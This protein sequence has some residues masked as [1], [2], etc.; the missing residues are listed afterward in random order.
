ME[1]KVIY[2]LKYLLRNPNLFFAISEQLGDFIDPKELYE[3]FFQFYSESLESRNLEGDIS[4]HIPD[5]VMFEASEAEDESEFQVNI[6]FNNGDGCILTGKRKDTT[7]I[8]DEGDL[9]RASY[10]YHSIVNN[11][12]RVCPEY[13]GDIYLVDA[14]SP[15]NDYLQHPDGS[16]DIIGL[17]GIHSDPKKKFRFRLTCGGDGQNTS[18]TLHPS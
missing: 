11:L 2:P 1:Y 15:V 3:F 7:G 17:M 8:V 16:G 18:V 14:P 10:I 5:Q 6:I 13:A 12:E 9:Q 4:D